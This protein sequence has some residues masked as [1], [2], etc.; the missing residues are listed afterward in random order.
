M[1]CLPCDLQIGGWRSRQSGKAG[2]G[3]W[4]AP[5]RIVSDS[6][7]GHMAWMPQG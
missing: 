1:G 4:R 6:K 5:K 2:G 3:V 7:A